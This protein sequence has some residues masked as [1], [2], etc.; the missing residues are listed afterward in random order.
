MKFLAERTG[1]Y[2]FFVPQVLN[3]TWYA[4]H[5]GGD[6][7]TPHIDN[8]AM[9]GLIRRFGTMI[10][11]TCGAH[12]LRCGVI[13]EVRSWRWKPNDFIDEGHFSGKG[14]EAFA[15]IVAD[16]IGPYAMAHGLLARSGSRVAIAH[17]VSAR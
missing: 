10:D 1:A 7:W 17:T 14:G 15:R 6:W 13:G 8:R 5:D 3:D 2:T 9:P 12:E 11:E 16:R 4:E